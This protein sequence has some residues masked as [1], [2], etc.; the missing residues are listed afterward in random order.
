MWGAFICDDDD[1]HARLEPGWEG[2]QEV[3]RIRLEAFG[4]AD[5]PN[6]IRLAIGGWLSLGE[7]P[8]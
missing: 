1:L 8:K 3:R 5:Y 4:K 6:R 7:S 2:Y